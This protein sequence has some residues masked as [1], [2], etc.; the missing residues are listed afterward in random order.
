MA[1]RRNRR[2]TTRRRKAAFN[3][4]NAAEL[5]VQTSILTMGAFNVNPIQFIT[6]RTAV[7]AGIAPVGAPS[8]FPNSSDSV[9]TLP[10]LIGLDYTKAGRQGTQGPSM[11]SKGSFAADPSLALATISANVRANAGQMIIQTL[12][13]RA[14]F[15]VAKRFTTKQRS[16]MNKA[17]KTVGLKEVKV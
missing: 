16:M 4:F 12:G 1:R 17:F 2:K 9:I 13:T 10:E 7:H 14:A 8:Y 5:Y 3:L 6:G 11:T 15:A